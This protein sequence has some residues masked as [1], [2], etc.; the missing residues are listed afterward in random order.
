MAVRSVNAAY[1]KYRNRFGFN[2]DQFRQYCWLR[3]LSEF[4]VPADSWVI[5]RLACEQGIYHPV[6]GSASYKRRSHHSRKH[7][8][9]LLS[10]G[11]VKGCKGGRICP[12]SHIRKAYVITD[13]G[14]EWLRAY[15]EQVLRGEL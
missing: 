9:E 10:L 14:K 2:H 11:L 3:C 13:K 4:V 8:L 5:A 6:G 7:M 15:E 12:T 1:E